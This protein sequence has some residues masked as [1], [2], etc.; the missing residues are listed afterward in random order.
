MKEHK[1]V[2]KKITPWLGIHIK[3]MRDLHINQ[4][5][6]TGL[7]YWR[8][9]LR[10]CKMFVDHL[11]T[12]KKSKEL[13]DDFV[14]RIFLTVLYHDVIED[15]KNGKE[16]LRLALSEEKYEISQDV[17]KNV[18]ILSKPKNISYE[19][20]LKSII[21]SEND[22]AIAVKRADI[23]DHVERLDL[24]KD[25][26]TRKKLAKKYKKWFELDK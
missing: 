16:K 4:V 19:D 18:Q 14:R 26:I 22:Y 24:I 3:Q 9:P 10:M 12:H 8:H 20:Y 25:D 21:T 1:N 5:D 15:V 2:M 23:R 13:S 6:K 7:P 17:Y 11:K